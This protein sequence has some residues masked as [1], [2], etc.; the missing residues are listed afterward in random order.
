MQL[1]AEIGVPQRLDTK[2]V[3]NH[4]ANVARINA[5]RTKQ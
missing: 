5:L 2:R 3:A 4:G 1:A